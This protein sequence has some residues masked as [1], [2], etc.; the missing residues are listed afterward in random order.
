MK[1]RQLFKVSGEM[2]VRGGTMGK[3]RVERR[4]PKAAG[5]V[6]NGE[7]ASGA[8]A[9]EGRR[10][11]LQWWKRKWCEGGRRPP[12]QVFCSGRCLQWDWML[13]SVLNAPLA[14]SGMG[15]KSHR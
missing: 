12:E 4:R 5:A 2:V 14:H 3:G 6:H 15:K 11:C 8:E 1:K 9:A 7:N 10:S 13:D